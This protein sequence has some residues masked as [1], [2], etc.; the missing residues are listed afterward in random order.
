MET[1]NF[2]ERIEL[3]FFH[4]SGFSLVSAIFHHFSPSFFSYFV[5]LYF[6]GC[7]CVFENSRKS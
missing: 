3:T 7:Y 1:I 4:C 6:W 5:L 2:M